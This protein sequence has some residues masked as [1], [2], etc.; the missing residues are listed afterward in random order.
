[1]YKEQQQYLKQF[2][3]ALNQIFLQ[4]KFHLEA[5]FIYILF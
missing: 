3:F 1:M 2:H 4:E 5:V